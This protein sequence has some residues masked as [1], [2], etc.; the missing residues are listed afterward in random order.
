MK[1]INKILVCGTGASGSSAI[2]EYL[3]CFDN[4]ESKKHEMKAIIRRKI[5]AKWVRGEYRDTRL[6][7]KE[8]SDYLSTIIKYDHKTL[9]LNNS[10]SCLQLRGVEL[11]TDLKVLCVLRDPRSTWIAWQNEWVNKSGNK[12]WSNCEDSV[13][14]FIISYRKCMLKFYK[15]YDSIKN[16]DNILII[17][18]EDFVLNKTCQE[19]VRW[20]S[21]L[22]ISDSSTNPIEA[23]RPRNRTVFAHYGYKRQDEIARIKTELKEYCHHL[24]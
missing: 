13:G 19:K 12:K 14:A 11:F 15:E 8:M 9:M 2:F 17:N 22:T 21:N 5:Y 1:T 10:L 7:R 23:L 24:V 4:V 18:F 20:F 16:K 6:F 3:E